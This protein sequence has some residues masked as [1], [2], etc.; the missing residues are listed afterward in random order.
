MTRDALLHALEGAVPEARS[1]VSE[2]LADNGE[3]LLHLLM[4]DLLRL[5]VDL[6]SGGDL[7]GTDRL[8]S[9][10]GN[11]FREGDDD[12]VNA[13]AVSFVEGFG[14][15][16]GESAALLAR[17]PRALRAELATDPRN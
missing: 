1:L 13:V 11:C 10:V 7:V 5:A 17:W 14:A 15:H 3:L 9:F 8:L 6:F 4:S 2:H 12:V 16:P